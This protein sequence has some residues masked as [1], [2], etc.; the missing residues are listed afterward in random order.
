[1]HPPGSRVDL[2]PRC[3]G[4]CVIVL[5]LVVLASWIQDNYHIPWVTLSHGAMQPTTAVC[6]GCLGV[7]LAS[8]PRP[9]CS[10][11]VIS[12]GMTAL[13]SIWAVATLDQYLVGADFGIDHWLFAQA[14]AVQSPHYPF[15][16]RMAFVTAVGMILCSTSLP[17]AWQPAHMWH[18]RLAGCAL[19]TN[20]LLVAAVAVL[21]HAFG[22]LGPQ[23]FGSYGS[24]ALPTSL[25]L[26]AIALGTLTLVADI[27]W[28]RHLSGSGAG[29]MAVRTLLLMTVIGPVGFG[30]IIIR[31]SQAGIYDIE[32]GIAIF[33]L[34]NVLLMVFMVVWT[35]QR[36]DRLDAQRHSSEGMFRRALEDA[37]FPAMVYAEDGH[38]VVL[39]HEWL[40]NT[41]YQR[42]QIITIND[43]LERAHSQ[44]K[45]VVMRNRMNW[46]FA[47]DEAIDE[48]EHTLVA[49]DGSRRVWALR[50]SPLGR[51]AAGRRLM[52][53]MAV[54]LTARQVADERQRLLM[55]EVNH[56]AK[57]ALTTVQA[58]L[59]LTRA[60]NQIDFAACVEGRI[61][62]L[63][64]AHTL[65]A[66]NQWSGVEIADMIRGELDASHKR[67]ERRIICDGPVVVVRAE[68]V[69]ALALVL[70]ELAVNA[71]HHGAL[72]TP[73]GRVGV[74]WSVI[75]A[76]GP[77][78]EEKWKLEILWH[79]QK[80]LAFDKPPDV[81][82]FGL[83]LVEQ[84]ICRQLMGTVQMDWQREGLL[85]TL[86][87]PETCFLKGGMATKSSAP[88]DIQVTAMPSSAISSKPRVLLVE[89]EPM[90][91]MVVEAILIEAGYIVL[92]PVD[93]VQK[94]IDL[95]KREL[96][97]AAVL[98]VNLSGQ[99]VYPVA[100]ILTS[101]SVPFIFCTGYDQLDVR[102]ER[103]RH[104]LVLAKPFQS[105]QLVKAVADLLIS[106]SSVSATA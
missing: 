32:F 53:S 34:C 21:G 68:A 64:S 18:L 22:I 101:L 94:A 30:W 59:R 50:A 67:H 71:V 58:I 6:L 55:H 42:D 43:W 73:K 78:A 97:D 15:P 104:A 37:P 27:G 99:P 13:V 14:V 93:Q 70:H 4:G 95:V 24:V 72:S 23:T 1:M 84:T 66:H 85:C 51:D 46:L 60:A 90:V 17:L 10:L 57:N 52:L 39:N 33:T 79:E 105:H 48:G 100:E 61:N 8:V 87:L 31:G 20:A 28:L 91:A 98:D 96:P 74:N 49:A 9:A 56:R 82:G 44:S 63:A 47:L 62:A 77:A 89:D 88:K 7:A 40:A 38:I 92:G 29:A 41:G 103:L 26:L 5:S 81:R 69:Q 76:N 3:L 83:M 65:L 12:T 19:A 25:G 36:I 54:D 35:A 75:E 11:P 45:S 16:G 80:E 86:V 106:N 102:P 2:L